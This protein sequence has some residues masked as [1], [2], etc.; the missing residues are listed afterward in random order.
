M[1]NIYLS[2][3]H[4]LSSQGDLSKTVLAIKNENI[5]VSS[6]TITTTME[7]VEAPYF[8]FEEEIEEK[9]DTIYKVLR[10]IVFKV[11]SNLDV[12]K[13]KSTAL[14]IGTSIVDLNIADAIECS[15]YKENKKE[16]LSHKYSVDSYAKEISKEFGL[17]D[18]TMTINT[19]CTSSANAILEAANLINSGVLDSVVV[20]GAEI[21]SKMMSS[22]FSGMKLLSLTHQKPFDKSRDGLILG[23]GLA[24]ILL[25][26]EKSPWVLRGG[27]S[28]CNSINITAVSEDGREFVEVMRNA[29]E[30]SKVSVENISALKTHATATSASDLSEINAI[31]EVFQTDIVFTA[32]KPYIGHTIGA[33]GVL[34]LCIFISCIDNNFV[35]KTLFCKEPMKLNYS[36][37]QEHK[38]CSSGVFMLNYFGFGGN[39]TSI[40]I[41]KEQK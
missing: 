5:R 2:D 26:R 34:E 1:P 39:N 11:L 37:L 33:C 21:Y 30:D 7:V 15:V 14:I 13:R 29:L 19:A 38:E 18:F 36:P 27:F 9:Q 10:D 32:L 41:E 22:G 23:E 4:I 3:Y 17:N 40:V 25:S 8:L 16:Y 35:P 24:G 20:I 12:E 6:K 31:S 28:N